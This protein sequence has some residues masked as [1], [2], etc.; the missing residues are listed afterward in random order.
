MYCHCI[1]QVQYSEKNLASN[2]S[3]NVA[4]KCMAVYRYYIGEY[5]QY[6]NV[7]GYSVVYYGEPHW[8]EV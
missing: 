2:Q 3:A 8:P 5:T 4:V 1:A 6:I 7:Q